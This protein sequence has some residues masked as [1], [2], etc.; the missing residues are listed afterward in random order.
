M[1]VKEIFRTMEYGPAPENDQLAKKWIDDHD[2]KFKL[3]I[4]GTWQAANSKK[5]FNS[6]NPSTEEK[7][8]RLAQANDQDV[9]RAVRA[10][11][12]ALPK[13]IALGAHQR[14]RY[15]YALARQIQKHARLFAV[16]E[17]MDNGKPIRETRDIDIPLVARHFYHHAGW[18]QLM[19][20]DLKDYK[21]LGV[22]GQIIPLEFSIAHVVL[23][24]STSYCY[25]KYGC[26]KTSRIHVINC[27]PLCRDL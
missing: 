24:N 18:A 26:F 20:S 1:K 14:A 9:D 8:G 22:I 27:P 23:E 11:K 3:Y 7:L 12:K 21:A 10:A 19:D 13:W 17:S 6:I 16:L 5:Y 15:M 2:G 25:G 4:D